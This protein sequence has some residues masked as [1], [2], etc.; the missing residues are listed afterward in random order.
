MNGLT[1]SDITDILSDY[2]I[3]YANISV[4]GDVDFY[5]QEIRINPV[6][7]QDIETLAHEFYHI[8]YEI[9]LEAPDIPEEIIESNALDLVR[10][11]KM[12]KCLEDYLYKRTK[13]QRL[14]SD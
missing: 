13:Y 11:Y 2:D 10:D 7:N 1:C 4:K 9:E 8:Y 5:S 14:E 6:Y 3:K 12:Y